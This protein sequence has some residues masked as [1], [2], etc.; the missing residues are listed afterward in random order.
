MAKSESQQIKMALPYVGE[1]STAEEYS[2]NFVDLFRVIRRGKKT[3]LV[4]TVGCFVIATAVAFLLPFR[5][6]S[7]TSFVPPSLSSSSSMASAV[8]GQLSALGAG[9]MLGG[10]KNPG[11][12][13]SGILKSKSIADELIKRFDLMNVY[14]VKKVSLAEKALASDTDIAVDTKSSIVRVE[15]TDKSGAST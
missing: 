14:K 4:V 11:D 10:V 1:L 3:L 5:Y 13:Y 6:T 2:I 12:L 8:A 7:S 15:V 9:D